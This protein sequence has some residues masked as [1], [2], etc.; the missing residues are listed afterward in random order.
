MRMLKKALFS[1]S[2]I[3]FYANN[4]YATTTGVYVATETTNSGKTVLLLV[5]IGLVALVLFIGYKM[6]K[7][8]AQE[9]RKE[10]IIRK[11]N[12][13]DA[14]SNMYSSHVE[15]EEIDDSENDEQD[16]IEQYKKASEEIAVIQTVYPNLNEEIEED[17]YEEVE[18]EV[19]NVYDN[20]QE[21]D[22]GDDY[23][24]SYDSTMVFDTLTIKETIDEEKTTKTTRKTTT[25][26]SSAKETTKAPKTTKKT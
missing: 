24:N 5:A 2:M 21:N 4:A 14:Y 25:K 17:S 20:Y 13:D 6:D 16:Y 15:K 26:K 12:A 8:E 18:E 3:L 23:Q 22:K 7:S 9:K 10:Q 11:N 19:V 1:L